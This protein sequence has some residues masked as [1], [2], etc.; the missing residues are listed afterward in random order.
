MGSSREKK[1]RAWRP[2]RIGRS[3][4]DFA[5]AGQY[6]LGYYGSGHFLQTLPRGD[7]GARHPSAF[8]LVGPRLR[9]A[10]R[11][12][13][14]WP[15]PGI[16]DGLQCACRRAK[17]GSKCGK[18][19]DRLGVHCAHCGIGGGRNRAHF[20][21]VKQLA[22]CCRSV[23]LPVWI[24]HQ[25]RPCPEM[26]IDWRNPDGSPVMVKVKDRRGRVVLKGGRP[27][28]RPGRLR[29]DLVVEFGG[30]RV[31]V[32]VAVVCVSA[33][34]YLR[35]RPVLARENRK[36]TKYGASARLAGMGFSPFVVSHVGGFGEAARAFFGRLQVIASELREADWRHSWSSVD[37]SSHWLQR[38]SVALA[39][40]QAARFLAAV[41]PGPLGGSIDG[42][43]NGADSGGVSP[44]RTSEN[45]GASAACGFAVELSPQVAIGTA[46]DGV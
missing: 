45:S 26:E 24:E 1:I 17:G 13:L 30:E 38:A 25:G 18:P 31:G 36:W 44:E 32:D 43:A 46:G 10:L 23:G 29:F 20:A 4:A 41:R 12:R 9:H 22:L 40:A 27:V 42:A 7:G 37:F 33:A 19:I 16:G 28:E 11:E 34:S 3:L 21:I 2:R 6:G 5:A 39:D 8:K 14:A 15:H 35:S